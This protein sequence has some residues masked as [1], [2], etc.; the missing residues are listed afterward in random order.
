[1]NMRWNEEHKINRLLSDEERIFHM[2]WTSYENMNLRLT[3]EH[4]MERWTS[5]KQI[6]II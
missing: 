2:K 1:M 6:T 3:D 5:D 4:Y